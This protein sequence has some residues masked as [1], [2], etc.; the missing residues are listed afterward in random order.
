MPFAFWILVLPCYAFPQTFDFNKNCQAAYNEIFSLRL[1]NGKSLIAEERRLHPDNLIPLLLESYAEFL[2]IL[3]SENQSL[4][5]VFKANKNTRLQ[6]LKKGDVHSPWNLHVQAEVQL[7]YALAA[8]QFRDYWSGIL[9]VRKAYFL[10]AENVGKFPHFKPSYKSL[11]TVNALLGSVPE[12]YQWGLR[13]LGLSGDLK[14]SLSSLEKLTRDDWEMESFLRDEVIHVYL[15]LVLHL[16]GDKQKAWSTIEKA[17]YPLPEN[18]FSYYTCIKTALY[19]YHNEEALRL[20]ENLPSGSEYLV[21]P[22]LE[23]YRGLAKLNR[24]DLRAYGD[25]NR[26]LHINRG[27]NLIKSAYQKMAWVKLLEG[28]MGAYAEATRTGKTKGT[29]QLDADRQAQR[30][31]ENGKPPHP[32]LLKARLLFDGGY[33]G[34]A[35]KTLQNIPHETL[36]EKPHRIEYIY[37]EAR[38]LH[39]SG[40][41]TLAIGKYLMTIQ[42]GK[43]QPYYF[44]SNAA[45]NLGLIYEAKGKS[46]LARKYF[47]QCM[48]MN[49]HEYRYSLTQKAKAGLQRL[50]KK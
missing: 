35:F 3:T 46:E 1:Q 6:L 10:L 17:G 31:A 22:V 8:I 2:H 9:D 47:S 32:E 13:L 29:A 15:S 14:G 38:I 50:D 43:D 37:R 5:P 12:K 39:E 30:E 11:L 26:F 4:L 36:V 45:F 41:T 34:K 42:E 33:F 21:L 28:N 25:F 48:Q 49:N 23:Y 24:L 19:T 16:A 7:H 40:D 44:A 27:Q 18:L 20:F